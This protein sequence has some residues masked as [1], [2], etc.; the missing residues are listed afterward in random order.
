MNLKCRIF[1]IISC[2]TILNLIILS[3]CAK[4]DNSQNK[5]KSQSEFMKLV[6]QHPAPDIETLAERSS[7]NYDFTDQNS[8]TEAFYD[9][10]KLRDIGDSKA[11]PVLEQII[12]DD[13]YKGRIHSYS[14]AQAL[15]C[16][17]TPQAQK[18]LDQYLL[19]PKYS[20]SQGIRYIFAYEMDRSKRKDFIE[21]YHLVNLSKDLEIKLNAEKNGNQ[22]NLA[23]T[24]KNISGKP[25]HV[26][27]KQIYLANMIFI[28]SPN[29]DFLQWLE[30]IRYDVPMPNWTEF[31]PGESR[32]YN[33]TIAIKP[34]GTQKSN[35]YKN[36]DNIKIFLET[37]DMI[38][39]LETPGE[40]KFYAMVEQEPLSKESLDY[41]Q[42]DNPWIGRAV[43]EPVTLKIK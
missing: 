16:I 34:K 28:Q 32:N 19:T 18:V 1:K 15:F 10:L 43:S 11:I 41:W 17:G 38:C 8:I 3:S 36:D 20:S 27:D 6:S 30:S 14:A 23:I 5:E 29:G 21:K 35:Y 9:I 39:G 13:N 2:I 37:N 7:P 22:V 25:Y 4:E 42:F 33:I 26:L 31:A 24:L 12:K 40:F